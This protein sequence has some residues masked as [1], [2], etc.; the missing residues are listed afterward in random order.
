MAPW[1]SRWNKA[2]PMEKHHLDK[3]PSKKERNQ[4]NTTRYPPAERKNRF[5]EK[6]QK[7]GRSSTKIQSDSK[8]NAAKVRKSQ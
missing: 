2:H 1:H 5:L 4:I 8:I 7:K 6:I 3:F